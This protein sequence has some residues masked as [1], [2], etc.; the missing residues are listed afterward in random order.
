MTGRKKNCKI[1]TRW[2]LSFQTKNE[3]ERSVFQLLLIKNGT[4]ITMTGIYKQTGDIL[5]ENGKISRI[6]NDLLR[7]IKCSAAV[8]P[9]LVLNAVAQRR[10]EEYDYIKCK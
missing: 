3:A 1:T 10:I 5:I 8:F 9:R 2:A 4:L 7:Y 6:G